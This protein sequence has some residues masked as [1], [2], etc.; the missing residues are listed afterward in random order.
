MK[1][2]KKKSFLLKAALLIFAVYSVI[3]LTQLQIQLIQKKEELERSEIDKKN[4]ALKTKELE[5]LLANGT[6]SDLIERA[7][8]DKLDYVYADEEVFSAQ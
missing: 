3:Q 5:D 4:Y 7:A 2:V 8:R 1:P 6:M